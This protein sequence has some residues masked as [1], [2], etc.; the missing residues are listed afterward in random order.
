MAPL[1]PLLLAP[2]LE[3]EPAL[4]PLL[5]ELP[6]LLVFGP[7]PVTPV[8]PLGR[9]EPWPGVTGFCCVTVWPLR[10]LDGGSATR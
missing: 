8:E 9:V 3:L 6:P 5:L 4:L 7:A 2:E 10:L 1:L